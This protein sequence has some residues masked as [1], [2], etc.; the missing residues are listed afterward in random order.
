MLV[1]SRYAIFKSAVW[2]HMERNLENGAHSVCLI[3]T[4]CSR[5]ALRYTD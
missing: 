1:F 2:L 4:L 3:S 5:R